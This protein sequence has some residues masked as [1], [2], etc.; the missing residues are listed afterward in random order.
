MYFVAIKM[1]CWQVSEA[2]SLP[3]VLKEAKP[4][5][6]AYA[7]V[8]SGTGHLAS[9]PDDRGRHDTESAKDDHRDRRHRFFLRRIRPAE[10]CQWKN[11]NNQSENETRHAWRN[12]PCDD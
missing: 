1:G 10:V 7:H 3:S 11:G 9:V 8:I 6:F 5:R 12:Q 4:G 2:S